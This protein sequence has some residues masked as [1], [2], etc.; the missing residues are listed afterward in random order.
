MKKVLAA[1]ALVATIL[2]GSADAQQRGPLYFNGPGSFQ[3]NLLISQVSLTPAATSAAIQT[4]TQSFAV[5]GVLSTDTVWVIGPTPTSLCP[6]VAARA[7]TTGNV[8]IDWAVLTAAACTPAAGTYT[9][10]IIR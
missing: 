3:G 1:L 5:A 2:C 9:V 8:A 10:L 4:A 6:M 7:G